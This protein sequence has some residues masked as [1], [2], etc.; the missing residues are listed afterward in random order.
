MPFVGWEVKYVYEKSCVPACSNPKVIIG[1]PIESILI[2]YFAFHVIC[3]IHLEICLCFFL[4]TTR[5]N[6]VV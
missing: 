3:V 4:G 2:T 6:E 1:G 5:R